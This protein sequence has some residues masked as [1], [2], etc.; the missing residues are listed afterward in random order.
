MFSPN[1]E[2]PVRKEP[3]RWR[4]Y[5]GAFVYAFV[6]GCMACQWLPPG[7]L[8][9]PKPVPEAPPPVDWNPHHGG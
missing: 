8:K 6:I 9:K 5:V 2:R 4:L 7:Y 3:A 1:E